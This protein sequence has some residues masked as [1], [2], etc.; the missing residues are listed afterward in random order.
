MELKGLEMAGC[1]EGHS[2][3]LTA[4]VRLVLSSYMRELAFFFLD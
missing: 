2:T 3:V 1:L 4:D